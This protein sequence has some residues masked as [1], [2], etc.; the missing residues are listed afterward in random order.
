MFKEILLNEKVY[1][2]DDESKWDI[3]DTS[4]TKLANKIGLKK[5]GVGLLKKF[6]KNGQASE[7]NFYD[8]LSNEKTKANEVSLKKGERLCRYMSDRSAK[9]GEYPLCAL[10]ADSGYMKFIDNIDSD[11]DPEDFKWSKPFK[12][13][14]LRVNY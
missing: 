5:I 3:I 10:N 9:I 11:P 1:R 7:M 6:A 14:Y 4:L 12:F 13:E 8:L 2:N